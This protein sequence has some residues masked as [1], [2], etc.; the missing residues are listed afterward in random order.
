[1][2]GVIGEPAEY[3]TVTLSPDEKRVALERTG[4]AAGVWLLEVANGIPTRF[5][6]NGSESDPIWSPGGRELV[7]LDYRSGS[8]QRKAIG[9]REEERPL[10]GPRRPELL[11]DTPFA[12][13]Q[14]HVS[15]DGR[16]IAFNSLESGRWEV[17][18]A[19]FPSFTDKRQVSRGG[20]GQP[21]WRKDG[22]ELFYSGLDGKLMAVPTTTGTVFDA[23][24]PASLFQAPINVDPI[25]DQY[26]VTH[27]GQRFI[28]APVDSEV[29]ITVVMNWAEGLHPSQPAARASQ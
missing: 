28:F 7:F 11:L 2:L 16:W 9:N 4:A 26:A 19:S 23:G 17:Y 5:T 18:V 20:G 24:A 12:K 29:P 21:L 14:F 13:D 1:V 10:S 25:I 8:L 15:P 27:D 6:F 3:G 22:K